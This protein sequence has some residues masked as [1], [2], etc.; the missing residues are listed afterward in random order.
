MVDRHKIYD[1]FIGAGHEEYSLH[2][3]ES[4]IILGNREQKK[5]WIYRYIPKDMK[6]AAALVSHLK[7]DSQ[8]Q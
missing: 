3:L 6:T 4:L 8:P 2:N 7:L 1:R 5:L